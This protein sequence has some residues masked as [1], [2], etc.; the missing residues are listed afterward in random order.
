MTTLRQSSEKAS[1]D[2][3]IWT[4][5]RFASEKVVLCFRGAD[6][7][8]SQYGMQWEVRVFAL[9]GKHRISQKVWFA[10]TMG[11]KDLPATKWDDLF[12]GCSEW[13]EH[14]V[15]LAFNAYKKDGSPD[16]QKGY[17]L[18][19]LERTTG[20]CPCAQFRILSE[21]KVAALPA[22]TSR[23]S[24]LEQDTDTYVDGVAEILDGYGFEPEPAP[25]TEQTKH[26]LLLASASLKAT[27]GV[28]V[29][30]GD[31]DTMTESA[32]QQRLLALRQQ[33]QSA[34]VAQGT[35]KL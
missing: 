20:Q 18:E 25:L 2:N 22:P 1:A 3:G 21:P 29:D 35:D 10:S 19:F 27:Y 7:V 31:I 13:P 15:L 4:K 14:N 17:H 33:W 23:P 28:I 11:S 5:E 12:S 30:P 6:V 16:L 8:D 34:S 32:G 26:K 9:A 24:A